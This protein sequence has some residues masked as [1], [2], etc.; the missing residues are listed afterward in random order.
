MISRSVVQDY[1]DSLPLTDLQP[2]SHASLL[3][4][5]QR[6]GVSTYLVL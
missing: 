3:Q 6:L 1:R 2:L 4:T 5:E